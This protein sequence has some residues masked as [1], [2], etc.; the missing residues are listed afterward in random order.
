MTTTNR[1]KYWKCIPD[2]TT[3]FMVQIL[4][5]QAD[6]NHRLMNI[7]AMW[8]DTKGEGVKLVVLDT[9]VPSHFDLEVAG[10]ESFIKGY[11][12]DRNGHSTFVG[13]VL[14][15]IA[16]ND[17]GVKGISPNSKCYYGAVLNGS[18]SG[19]IESIVE[20]IR[21]A[22]DDVKADVV[23]MSLGISGRA[24]LDNTLED[25]CEYAYS[26]NVYLVAAAGNDRGPVNHPAR[27]ETVVAVGAIDKK[28]RS[29]RFT[30]RG[31]QIQYVAGGVNTY[32]TTLN[33]SYGRNSGT[34]FSCPAIA[35]VAAL[36][37]SSHRMRGKSLTPAEV[38]AHIDRIA[39][40]LSKKQRC[41]LT[42]RGLPIFTEQGVSNGGYDA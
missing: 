25:I 36:I 41:P 10:G 6:Y 17:M 14:N 18:G 32:S 42:G 7:P 26:K 29:A 2:F 8:K 20:G 22:V 31:P 3:E 34:S 9:G 23:N 15:A 13:G 1:Q 4:A 37:I 21:W 38:S 19:T 30:S 5:E 27:Y 33:N 35:G 11:K 40:R 28:K 24:K 12:R 16:D 39:V